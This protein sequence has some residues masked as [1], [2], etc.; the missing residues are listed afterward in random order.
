MYIYRFPSARTT[1]QEAADNIILPV[2]QVMKTVS[3]LHEQELA[4]TSR[5]SEVNG[6][7]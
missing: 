1:Q 7:G 4:A 6:S 2:M 5:H 3:P